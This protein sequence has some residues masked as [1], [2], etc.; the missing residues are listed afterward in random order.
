METNVR[1]HHLAI[2][3]EN[4]ER[5]VDWYKKMLGLE[6]INRMTIE[7][8]GTKIAFVGNEQFVIEILEVP[9]HNPIPADRSHPDTDNATC[10]VK[11][12]C[13]ITDNNLDY[14]AWLKSQGVKV[15]FEFQPGGVESYAAFINDPD[16]NVIEVF[17]SENLV[18]GRR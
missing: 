18:C 7:H 11:H 8:N 14:I 3:V 16:G 17:D 5:S 15:V 1:L 2:S 12:F 10:G 6:V 13:I 4:L 9:D